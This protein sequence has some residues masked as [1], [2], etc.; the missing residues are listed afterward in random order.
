MNLPYIKFYVRDWISDPQ[1]RMVSIAARGFWFE[2]LCLMHMAA[3]RGYLETPSGKPINEEQLAR[4]SGTF[5]GEIKGLKEELLEHGIPSV[6]ESTGIWYS[7]RMVKESKKADK[8]SEAGKRGGGNP[9][10]RE[11]TRDQSSDTKDQIPDTRDHISLKGTFKGVKRFIKPTAEEVTEYAKSIDFDLDG[12]MF[13][14]HYEGNG[15]M[16][17]KTPMKDWQAVVRTWK[18][19]P[20]DRSNYGRQN[21]RRALKDK[22]EFPEDIKPRIIMGSDVAGSL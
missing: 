7:R 1:L 8:C 21:E 3:R 9:L 17:G 6:E 2:C 19:T 20:R 13:V 15:W 18:K 11:N 22:G 12:E 5:I 4:L 10:L 14:D 16:R